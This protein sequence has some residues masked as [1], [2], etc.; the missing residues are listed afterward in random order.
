VNAQSTSADFAREVSIGQR[1]EFG[2]N[3]AFGVPIDVRGA[4]GYRQAPT[5]SDS[6][7]SPGI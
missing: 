5:R 3:W 6:L 2:R 4:D 7:S 1:F